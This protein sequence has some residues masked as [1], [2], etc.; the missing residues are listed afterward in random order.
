MKSVEKLERHVDEKSLIDKFSVIVG[1][2]KADKPNENKL[3]NSQPSLKDNFNLLENKLASHKNIGMEK[4][5]NDAN[6]IEQEM[7][8]VD[9]NN[10]ERENVYDDYAQHDKLTSVSQ[11]KQNMS[12]IPTNLTGKTYISELQKQ[13][14]EEREAR[15]KLERDLDDLRKISS[16]ITSQLSAIQKQQQE[17]GDG[18]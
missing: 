15:K 1:S 4:Q 11:I 18:K 8:E 5:F 9:L 6:P 3:L 16:E 10:E 12:A 13:L 2:H 17:N 14:Q 7:I